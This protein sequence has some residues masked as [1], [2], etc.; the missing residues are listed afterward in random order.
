[1]SMNPAI[2]SED[3]DDFSCEKIISLDNSTRFVGVASIEGHFL[4][5][6]YRYGITPCMVE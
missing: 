3:A 4:D 5:L 1:M 6:K 2:Y